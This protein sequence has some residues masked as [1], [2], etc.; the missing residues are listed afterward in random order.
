VILYCQF[1]RQLI[2]STKLKKMV[3]VKEKVSQ[4]MREKG[5][6]IVTTAERSG[7]PA[8]TIKSI[9]Y[10]KSNNQ[11]VTTLEKLA[12]VFECSINDLLEEADGVENRKVDAELFKE[13]LDAVELFLR[14]KNLEIR[15]EK[16]MMVIENLSSLLIKK[17]NKGL[18]YSIDD[19]TIEWIIDNTK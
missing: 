16:L 11:K 4:C 6:S 15:K 12:K 8:A 14:K 19:E 13:C 17:K 7:V 10:G 5:W 1:Q 18:V 3:S 2:D 9:I